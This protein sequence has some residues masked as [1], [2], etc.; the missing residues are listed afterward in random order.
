M[1]DPVVEPGA[2]FPSTC[3]KQ[4]EHDR[5]TALLELVS[6]LCLI[7]ELCAGSVSKIRNVLRKADP[8]CALALLAKA[9]PDNAA[10]RRLPA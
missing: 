2:I 8:S 10:I 5:V 9:V 3:V 4:S 7:T 1:F 6:S